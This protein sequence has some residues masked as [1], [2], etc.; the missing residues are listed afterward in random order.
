MVAVCLCRSCCE[1]AGFEVMRIIT[2]SSAVCLAHGQCSV[3][4]SLSLSLSFFLF[5]T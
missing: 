2:E 1:E 3:Y 5:I 4:I